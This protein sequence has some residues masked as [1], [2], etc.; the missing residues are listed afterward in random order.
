MAA[1]R[2]HEEIYLRPHKSNLPDA[3]QYSAVFR[4]N[5]GWQLYHGDGGTAVVDL[6]QGEWIHVRVVVQGEKAAVFV[7]DTEAPALVI[8]RLARGTSGGFVGLRSFLPR[9]TDATHGAHFANLEVRPGKVDFDF[10]TVTETPPAPGTITTWEI[11]DA[12]A[13]PEDPEPAL[14]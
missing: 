14:P 3:L 4:G 1:D 2:D 8:P 6:P 5:S 11:S 12:V 10:S 13:A 9:G 7:G